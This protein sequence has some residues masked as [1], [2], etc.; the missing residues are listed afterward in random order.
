MKKKLAEP[1]TD[2][3]RSVQFRLAFGLIG[4]DLVNWFKLN[5]ERVANCKWFPTGSKSDALDSYRVKYHHFQSQIHFENS[6]LKK[7]IKNLQEKK[8][9]NPSSFILVD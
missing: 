6:I 7:Q 2:Y 9:I 3:N 1:K 8:G 4:L 5:F